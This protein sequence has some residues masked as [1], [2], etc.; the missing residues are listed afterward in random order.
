MV[1][2]WRRARHI[3]RDPLPLSHDNQRRSASGSC[4]RSRQ[5]AAPEQLRTPQ[6]NW[7]YPSVTSGS[8]R[9]YPWW[10]S[11]ILERTDSRIP[12]QER[13]STQ[14]ATP[15]LFFG[16]AEFSWIDASRNVSPWETEW[17]AR[18]TKD[19]S[20]D[21][22]LVRV[23]L[24]HAQVPHPLASARHRCAALRCTA[25]GL[26]VVGQG[27]ALTRLQTA[28]ALPQPHTLNACQIIAW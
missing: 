4:S 8:R 10:P 28:A 17:D 7:H 18:S 3:S 14:S 2:V 21:F 12:P 20:A 19:D 5:A 23:C 27:R 6:A 25:L 13:R 11:L 15:V 9:R 1:C 22:E 24:L 16:T 26:S